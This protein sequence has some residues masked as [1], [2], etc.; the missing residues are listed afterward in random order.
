MRVTP[1]RLAR[2]L[3]TLGE[4]GQDALTAA[5]LSNAEGMGVSP[6]L[7]IDASVVSGRKGD[8][9]GERGCTSQR[10]PCLRPCRCF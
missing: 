4:D 5:L 10:R 3:A 2:Q 8:G 7:G 1:E 9:A 6:E